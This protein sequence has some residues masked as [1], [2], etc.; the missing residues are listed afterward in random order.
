MATRQEKVGEDDYGSP[1]YDVVDVI[2][3]TAEEDPKNV[4]FHPNGVDLQ[5]RSTGEDVN[6]SPAVEARGDLATILSEGDTVA[7]AALSGGHADYDDLEIR[8]VIE[9]YGRR[10]RPVKT[11]VETED[12]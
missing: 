10:S 4:R 5:R 9:V 1:V 11:V 3:G 2:G 8:A 7:L 12:L 6:R